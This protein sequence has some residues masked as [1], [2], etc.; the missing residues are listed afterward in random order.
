ME[1]SIVIHQLQ[2]QDFIWWD[3]LARVKMIE[4]RYVSWKQFK[5]YFQ[6]KYLS[7]HYFER[8]MQ[9]FFDLKMGSMTMDEYVNKFLDFMRYVD[10]IKY[11]KIKIQRFL[12]GF[13]SFYKD[14]I[15]YDEPKSL[16]EAIRKSKHMYEQNKGKTDFRRSWKD[17]K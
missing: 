16:E 7:K 12:S 10:C 17:K 11:D 5:K 1:V 15:Q 8:K 6:Q 13:P 14:R 3:Q 4:E 9:E 2:G